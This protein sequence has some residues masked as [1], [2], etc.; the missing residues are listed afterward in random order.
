MNKNTSKDTVEAVHPEIL[1]CFDEVGYR[2]QR[3]AYTRC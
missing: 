1:P 2:N 3:P